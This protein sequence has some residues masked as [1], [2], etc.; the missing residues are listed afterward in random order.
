M[1]AE[2][3]N[4]SKI[5][6]SDTKWLVIRNST[7]AVTD[8]KPSFMVVH[9]VELEEGVLVCSCGLPHRYGCPCRHL[10]SLEPR[11]DL[12]DIAARWHTAFAY[13]AYQDKYENLTELYNTKRL[14]MKFGIMPKKM[15]VSPSIS[16]YPHVLPGCKHDM[17]DVL[18]IY[19]STVP[20][21]YNY[22][23]DSYPA[24]F[25][26]YYQAIEGGGGVL[27]SDVNLIDS[28]FDDREIGEVFEDNDF[29]QESVPVREK[30]RV[31]ISSLSSGDC[32][33]EKSSEVEE[34]DGADADCLVA[35]TMLTLRSKRI[36][37]TVLQGK[38]TRA[39]LLNHFKNVLHLFQT[40][41]ELEQLREKI[42]SIEIQKK[43]ELLDKSRQPGIV[44]MRNNPSYVSYNLP[45]DRDKESW[46][47]AN[48]RSW[49]RLHRDKTGVSSMKGKKKKAKFYGVAK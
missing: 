27:A 18:K 36:V 23:V 3:S 4:Y 44:A 22:G 37:P 5:R 13:Y 11:Y 2:R 12:V 38:A 42:V 17:E 21:C 43:T 33:A 8:M 20:M 40:D 16:P 34:D 25:R 9:V 10:L 35:G 49:S 28:P 26:P 39:K 31:D 1:F 14:T 15:D 45:L 19:N 7:K 6:L 41:A 30:D 29:T 48:K 24:A 46:Q 32:L 47:V